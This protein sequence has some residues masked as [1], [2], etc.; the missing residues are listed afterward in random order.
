[1]KQPFSQHLNRLSVDTEMR[2]YVEKSIAIF[3]KIGQMNFDRW[4]L[5]MSG[6]KDSTLLAILLLEYLRSCEIVAPRVDVIYTDSLLEFPQAK[7]VA[8]GLL[9]FVEGLAVKEHLPVKVHRVEPRIKDTYWVSVIG[10]GYTPPRSH[11]RWC[12]PRLKI[13]PSRHLIAEDGDRK[14]VLTGVR[15]DESIARKRNLTQSC[16]KGGECGQDFW[17]R[18]GPKNSRITYFAPIVF[19]RTCKVWD[20]LTIVAPALGWP[21]SPLIGLYNGEALRF[22]CWTCTLISKDRAAESLMQRDNDGIIRRLHDF[23]SFL[24]E[25]SRKPANRLVNG[26]GDMRGFTLN[27]RK[28]LLRRLLNLQ[29]ELKTQL[30]TENEINEIA[31]IWND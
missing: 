25:S 7:S 22:G 28:E 26:A 31:R 20:F 15:Y 2:S 27:F 30:I 12:T 10:R 24:D 23:R 14:A 13:L 9:E 6:G 8:L 17:I 19:W 16:A 11:F 3:P 29:H 5:M 18:Y 1:M 21:T 4:V